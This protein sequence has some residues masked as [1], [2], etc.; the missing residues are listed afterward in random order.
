MGDVIRLSDYTPPPQERHVADRLGLTFPCVPYDLPVEKKRDISPMTVEALMFC[1][2][3][4]GLACLEGPINRDR[5]WCCDDIAIK[6]IA[7]RLFDLEWSKDDVTK[8][9]AAWQVIKRGRA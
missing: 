3:E 4:R 9:V 7:A 2:R 6:Q 1:L 5:L 8:L